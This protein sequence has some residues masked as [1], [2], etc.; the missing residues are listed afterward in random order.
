MIVPA[1]KAG[2]EAYAVVRVHGKAGP[3]DVGDYHLM[4]DEL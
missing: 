3:D 2:E 1:E 4:R